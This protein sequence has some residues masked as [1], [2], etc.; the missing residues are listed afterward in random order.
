MDDDSHH[1]VPTFLRRQVGP[2]NQ[3]RD[4]KRS[5]EIFQESVQ[6]YEFVPV[7]TDDGF[8]SSQITYVDSSYLSL[9]CVGTDDGFSS[10]RITYVDS[11]YLSR[12]FRLMPLK[13]APTHMRLCRILHDANAPHLWLRPHLNHFNQLIIFILRFLLYP[14]FLSTAE[15]L[16]KFSSS[17]ARKCLGHSPRPPPLSVALGIVPADRHRQQNGRQIWCFFVVFI[18]FVTPLFAGAI[19]CKY[20]PDGGVQWR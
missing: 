13:S 10:S 4:P 15:A 8:I 9:V 20:S 16:V 17:Q 11:S 5:K 7:G 6:T 14:C 19:L 3:S 1:L 18:Q 2:I 12:I